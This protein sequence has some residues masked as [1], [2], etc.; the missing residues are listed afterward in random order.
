M[1]R[2]LQSFVERRPTLACFQPGASAAEIDAAEAALG[3]QIPA[4][5]REFLLRFDGGFISL[6]GETSAPDWD[7]D[8][9]AWNSNLLL[10]TK[11]LVEE[12]ADQSAIWRLD[13]GWAGVWPYL[14][15]CHTEGQEWLVFGPPDAADQRPVRDAFHEVGPEEWGVLYPG[16]QEFLLAYVQGEG[17][18]STV[19]ESGAA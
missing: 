14:P 16:F 3:V 19:A 18:V 5:Y 1:I 6:C 15:F 13:R 4:P 11:K 10:G 2:A 7:Y 17:R 12:Y 9:A 8:S